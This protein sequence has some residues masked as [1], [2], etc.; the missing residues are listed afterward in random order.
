MVVCSAC[1]FELANLV[2]AVALGLVALLCPTIADT[3]ETFQLLFGS[4]NVQKLA[5]VFW[6]FVESQ[7]PDVFALLSTLT[8]THYPSSLLRA[9]TSN[10]PTLFFAVKKTLPLAAQPHD[11]SLG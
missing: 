2:T 9:A 5:N 10:R 11:W 6:P 1:F 7:A 4:C 3:Q 8:S